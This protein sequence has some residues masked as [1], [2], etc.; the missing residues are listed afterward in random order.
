[1]LAFHAYRRPDDSTET[2]SDY[3]DSLDVEAQRFILIG[4]AIEQEDA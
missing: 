2:L 1:L 4:V 3:R